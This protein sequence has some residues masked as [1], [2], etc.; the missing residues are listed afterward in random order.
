[1]DR[2]LTQPPAAPPPLPP[3]VPAPATD[4]NR[5]S[6][7]AP[8]GKR[9]RNAISVTKW[10]KLIEKYKAGNYKSVMQF[11][12]T[13]G[14]DGNRYKDSLRRRIQQYDAGMLHVKTGCLPDA[15]RLRTSKYADVEKKLAE[16]IRL[17]RQLMQRDKIGLSFSMLQ[18]TAKEFATRLGHTH[19]FEASPGWIT[20]VLK[21]NNLTS[22]HLQGE[23]EEYSSEEREKAMSEFK[24]ITSE[25]VERCDI[26]TD[27]IYNADQ[28][29]LFYQKLPNTMYV[30]ATE[31]TTARGVKQMRDK[32]RVT[33]MVCTS[34][35]GEKVPLH[36]VGKSKKP[37][38]FRLLPNGKPPL[39]YTDQKKAWYDGATTI[40]WINELFAPYVRKRHG[41]KKVILFL[42][43]CPAHHVNLHGVNGKQIH[44]LFFP[45]NLTCWHQPA[46]MGII[47][48]LK[49]G[50]KGN[51]LEALL[52][53][54]DDP[55]MY[56]QAK[57]LG[58]AAPRGC[59]GLMHAS[60]P[61]LVDAMNILLKVW[62]RP[63]KY[64]TEDGIVRCWLRANC[65][66]THMQAELQGQVEPGKNR[67]ARYRLPDVEL[68]A[69]C[70]S[71]LALRASVE[72][73][74]EV[75]AAL[76]ESYTDNRGPSVS[77][78]KLRNMMEAWCSI[79]DQP[80][81]IHQELEEAIE[82]IN[83]LSIVNENAGSVAVD[84]EEDDV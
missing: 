16:Y 17:R 68:N 67:I 25:L 62:T 50:Y 55:E 18:T 21:R 1:M 32:T 42:D 4:R 27:R 56:Q 63:D 24:K 74:P 53:I 37:A 71:M 51:L 78:D 49:T 46:D 84:E 7:V 20:K 39:F 82:E 70:G 19:E 5:N 8:C 45:P 48:S 38:C 66:P 41:D 22:V 23:A 60:K 75:P 9:S 33:L 26:S 52:H 61:H 2:W 43:N 3:V 40:R 76:D 14:L 81:V 80:E 35:V 44:V 15:K 65:L 79:E 34:A 12:R 59:R 36:I 13:E 30:D 31:R 29:G 77:L 28:T 72:H 64:C 54:C 73:L 6:F 57:T 47:Q 83:D 58:D 69:L 11:L 10:V